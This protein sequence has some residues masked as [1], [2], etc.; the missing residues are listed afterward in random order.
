[1]LSVFS[2]Q[3]MHP[4]PLCNMTPGNEDEGKKQQEAENIQHVE[5]KN[6]QLISGE[7]KSNPQLSQLVFLSKICQNALEFV[8]HHGN[9][10]H[11]PICVNPTCTRHHFIARPLATIIDT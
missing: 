4:S 2:G 1:M 5:M 6:P 8:V 7:T 3:E 9:I 11:I 10:K